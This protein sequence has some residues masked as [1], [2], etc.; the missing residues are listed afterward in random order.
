MLKRVLMGPFSLYNIDNFDEW[1]LTEEEL[2]E[3]E[4]D[5]ED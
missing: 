2:E 3:L 4:E 5:D 1:A